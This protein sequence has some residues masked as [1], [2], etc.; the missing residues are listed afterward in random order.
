VKYKKKHN[1]LK[2]NFL[3]VDY[4][5]TTFVILLAVVLFYFFVSNSVLKYLFLKKQLKVLKT[6]LLQ[7]KQE[8][9]KLEEEIYLL[10]T[11]TDTIE[12]Y[13]R[14]ELNYKKPNEKVLIIK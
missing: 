6:Q 12:Y 2:I 9:K 5:N 8:N 4:L 13:I 10:Q 1:E 11:D 3:K 7:I 14:K